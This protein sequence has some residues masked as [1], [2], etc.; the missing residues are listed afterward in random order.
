M[1]LL[2][3]GYLVTL[4]PPHRENNQMAFTAF[5]IGRSA[6]LSTQVRG[7]L[8]MVMVT[9]IFSCRACSSASPTAFAMMKCSGSWGHIGG[10]QWWWGGWGGRGG[11][12]GTPWQHLWGFLTV[13]HPSVN[14]YC[15]DPI[16]WCGQ[17]FIIDHWNGL[18]ED[19][20]VKESVK[21]YTKTRIR[22]TEY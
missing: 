18:G 21:K 20:D 14:K 22:I 19:D 13:K 5:Q 4:I 16:S 15:N 9:V 12:G 3:L 10:E 7:V 17:W 8:F 2:G 6:L 1:P 11:R